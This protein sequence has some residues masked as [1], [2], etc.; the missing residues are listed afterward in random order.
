[1][2]TEGPDFVVGVGCVIPGCVPKGPGDVSY[3]IVV[4]E[5]GVVVV[6]P[7]LIVPDTVGFPPV[8]WDVAGTFGV[9]RA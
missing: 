9:T 4:A 5:P 2:S 1:M 6:D 7:G 8:G 3:T